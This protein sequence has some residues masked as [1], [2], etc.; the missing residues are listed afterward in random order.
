MKSMST[1][2]ALA[3]SA[4][5]LA[6]CAERNAGIPAELREIMR[7]GRERALPPL[8]PDFNEM[9][10]NF[11][12]PDL[13]AETDSRVARH[14]Q[15]ESTRLL[16]AAGLPSRGVS[17]AISPRA[18]ISHAEIRDELCFLFDLLRYGYVG[19][20]H[21][22]GDAV[23]LPL[24]DSML[25]SL[26]LMRDPLPV[27]EYLDRLLVPAFR[28]V[29]YDNHFQ[30]HNVTMRARDY[31]LHMSRDFV[32]RRDRAGGFVTEIDGAARRVLGTTLRDGT[33]VDGILPTLTREGELAW[34]FGLLA[35]DGDRQAWEIVALLECARTGER[36]SLVASLAHVGNYNPTSN[37]VL[38]TRE[39][40]GVPILVNRTM[41]VRSWHNARMEF[42]QS[43]IAL[44]DKPVLV[45]DLRGHSGGGDFAN[46]W[47][48]GY[49]GR[50]PNRALAFQRFQLNSS[51]AHTL[52]GRATSRNP[53]FYPSWNRHNAVAPQRDLIPNENLLIVLTDKRVSSGGDL[54][55][56]DLRQLE[57]ALF[58]GTNTH[59]NIL[60][61]GIVRSRLPHSGIDIIFGQELH[62]RPDLSQFEGIGF[63]PDLWVPPGESLERV[64]AFIER[65]G[66]NR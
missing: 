14:I 64:L 13:C 45:L 8:H 1:I 27:R 63:L 29:I 31:R 26:A 58:V 51:V 11:L 3:A 40:G 65:Y 6:S 23:F 54:F 57:N 38:E 50:M 25:E 62:V 59:G 43:G 55:V 18:L 17:A 37:P 35:A 36:S 39:V 5:L 49:T 9:L 32:L 24:R 21:F 12:T 20:Q 60:S 61:G 42:A 53:Y 30:I 4:L 28:G 41:S 16:T 33:P 52:L 56:G 44:R 19:Y 22:G 2:F 7:A 34:M 10:T 15:W 46:E 47:I 66:L 48:S